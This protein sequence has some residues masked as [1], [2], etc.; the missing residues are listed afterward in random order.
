MKT[1]W[2]TSKEPWLLCE[3][4]RKDDCCTNRFNM[5]PDVLRSELQSPTEAHGGSDFESGGLSLYGDEAQIAEAGSLVAH[6]VCVGCCAFLA[7]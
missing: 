3:V 4:T 5:D 1:V 2:P 7:G 6:A